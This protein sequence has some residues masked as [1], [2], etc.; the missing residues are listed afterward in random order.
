M[1]SF[2]EWLRQHKAAIS[3]VLVLVL[4]LGAW[5]WFRAK[6]TA[7]QP[8]A[9]VRRGRIIESVYGIGTVTANRYYHVRL[10]MTNHVLGVFV[11]EGDEVKK[12]QLLITFEGATFQAPFAGYVTY[13]PYKVGEIILGNSIAL[14]LVDLSDRYVVVSVEQR[15]AL[16]VRKGQKARINFDS[17]RAETFEGIVRSVYSN[18]NVFL[19]R[20]D[21][22]NLPSEV[23]PDMTGDVAIETGIHENALL[24]PAAALENDSVLVRGPLGR[25]RS[26]PLNIGVADGEWVEITGG[27]LHEGDQILLRGR[28]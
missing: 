7:R 23:L 11:K 24:V 1:K 9:V 15:G 6:N 22:P 17:M 4:A 28:R 19:V 13:L 25:P 3:A 8:T 20:I 27:E 12:G 18:N 21:V 5:L 14:T 2:G 26:I 16:R 10:G